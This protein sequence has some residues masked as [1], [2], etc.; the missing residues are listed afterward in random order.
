MASLKLI[1]LRLALWFCDEVD[2]ADC[3][4][5]LADLTALR[6]KHASKCEELDVITVELAEQQSRRTLLGACTSYP[7]LHEKLLSFDLAMFRL[8]LI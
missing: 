2:C 1:L 5:F 7:G 8:R 4:V 3:F 6:E